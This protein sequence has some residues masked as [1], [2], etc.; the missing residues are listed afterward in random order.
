MVEY[1]VKYVHAHRHFISFEAKFKVEKASEIQLQ[2]PAW[3]PG[4][5]ELGNFAKNIRQ[6]KVRDEKNAALPYKKIS[7]DCWEVQTKEAKEVKL[8][9]EF[10]ASELNAGS[11]YLDE[12]MLYINPVNCFFYKVGSIED[13]YIVK[14]DLPENYQIASGLKKESKHI[15]F[16]SS[17]DELAD[18]PL[19]A[20]ANL[21]HT[22]YVSKGV[23]FNIWIQGD[24]EVSN[25]KLCSDFQKFTDIHFE[26][27]GSI[28]CDEYHFLFH[29]LP[30]F[31]RHGV[32]HHNS[33][34]IAMGPATEMATP[35]GYEDFLAISCHELFHTWNI[36]C[37][38]P[39]EMMPYD[40]T[41]ENYSPLGYV[42]EGV[43]TYYGDYLLYRSGIV[44]EQRWLEM[45]SEWIHEHRENQGRYN[46]SV[47][48]SSMDTWLDGYSQGIPW[49]KV[50][51]YTE[52]ALIAFIIDQRIKSS[53]QNQKSLDDVMKEMYLRFGQKS[54]G[55]SEKD[56]KNVLEE[57]GQ[58]QFDDIYEQLIH[59][60]ADYTSYLIRAL[61]Y[62]DCELILTSMKSGETWY[63]MKVEEQV[64]KVVVSYIKE[65]GPAD[66]AGLWIGDEIISINGI[67]PYKNFQNTLGQ[68]KD[69]ILKL[70]FFR[71]GQL[72]TCTIKAS[73]SPVLQNHLVVKKSS[74]TSRTEG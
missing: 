23:N 10:Y 42:A 44:S 32:E 24:F 62:Y 29:L 7:K 48:E 30:Y 57:V 43:T 26:I 52:G 71:K 69:H 8:T 25:E 39:I 51:I 67:Q 53:T 68:A 11:T 73:M 33:T 59:S 66:N 60:P 40:F 70:N 18:S 28:P 1:L 17:F 46:L 50:S 2:L 35:N 38:R 27:F 19:I 64:N 74:T 20:S 56:F 36:K 34:V 55:Y 47:A 49:R 72:R 4:R 61:D 45:L 31:T 21:R 6:W 58:T 12:D 5:Y 15:L 54:K 14:F 41:K 22:S 13:S 65:N 63:G 9:Y 37:I 3:R 16:A